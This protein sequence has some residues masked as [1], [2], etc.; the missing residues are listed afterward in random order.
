METERLEGSVAGTVFRNEENGY[1]VIMV[2]AGRKAITCTGIL[3]ELA[4]GEQVVLTGTYVDH[5]Q[6]G[7]QLKVA[8]FEIIKP[9]TLSGIERFLASGL[10]KGVKTSSAKQIVEH[11][12]EETLEVL[13]EHPERLQEIRGFGKKRW[14]MVAESYHQCMYLRNAMVFLQTYSIPSTLAQRIARKYG[15]DTEKT[16]N[17]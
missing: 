8:S 1:S 17:K 7:S 13:S 9:T 11:F 5:P 16:I 4:I 12:G 15:S 10:I 6:Y 2:K 14:K 3:P